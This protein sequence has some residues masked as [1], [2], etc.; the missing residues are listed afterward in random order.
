MQPGRGY[1][2][3]LKARS[4]KDGWAFFVKTHHSRIVKPTLAEEV[5]MIKCEKCQ[6]DYPSRNYFATN[7]IC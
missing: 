4:F 5:H 1:G 2:G 7:T 6:K 3:K